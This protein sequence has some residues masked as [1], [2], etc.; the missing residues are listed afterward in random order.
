MA[1]VKIRNA[2]DTGWI[3]IGGGQVI[4]QQDSAPSTTSPG[5]LWLDTDEESL[6]TMLTT[7]LILYVATTG[8]DTTGDG[9]STA[10]YLTLARALQRCDTYIIMS[11]VTITISMGAGVFNSATQINM[12]H[13]Q[14]QQITIT[15]QTDAAAFQSVSSY[16]GSAQAWTVVLNVSDTS[17]LEVGDVIGISGATGGTR[18]DYL[19]GAFQISAVVANTSITFF[20]HHYD[21]LTASGACAGTITKFRTIMDFDAGCFYSN[22]PHGGGGFIGIAIRGSYDDVTGY[23]VWA[24]YGA[25]FKVSGC[26]FLDVTGGVYAA[27][28]SQIRMAG[29]NFMG[30]S[31]SGM[32]LYYGAYSFFGSFV[33][34]EG[35]HVCGANIAIYNY[36]GTIE[37]DNAKVTGCSY[38][39]YCISN[40]N[41]YAYQGHATGISATAVYSGQNG[42]IHAASMTVS[43]NN[44]DYSP[45]LN[46]VGNEEAYNNS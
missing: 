28:N 14:S 6:P 4:T 11:G 21:T 7:S 30:V 18:P 22:S 39:F 17:D 15:G 36:G 1:I 43:N 40:G 46:T 3:D 27:D 33:C 25:T 44:I 13:P 8:N 19:H 42:F 16:T 34:C 32:K 35:L 2:A 9:S 29:T 41:I 20:S 38:G 31:A 26:A 24:A 5:M 12:N 45:A 10:P 37:A 23:G